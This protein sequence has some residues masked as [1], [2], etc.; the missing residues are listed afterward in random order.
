MAD[1]VRKTPEL[2]EKEPKKVVLKDVTQHH[3]KAAVTVVLGGG[4]AWLV[5]ALAT[6]F[7]IWLFN[8]QT[9]YAILNERVAA[10]INLSV[11]EIGFIAAVYTWVF[12]I[13]QLFSG[14]LLDKLGSRKILVPSIAMVS[15]GVFVYAN[16]TSFSG[17]LVSQI[18]IAIGSCA[19]FVGAGYVGG[20]WFGMAKFGFMFGLVQML[21]ALSS[22]FGQNLISFALESTDWR[23]L[24][25]GFGAFGVALL[26]VSALF[27]K[28]PT[29]VDT[30]N[31]KISSLPSD[32]VKSV[33]SVVKNRQI[34]LIALVGA[35]A[36]G[37]L[38]A[39]GVVWLPKLLTAHG[40][41]YS[42]TIMASSCLWLGLAFGSAFIN[43]ISEKF[44][45]RKHVI[46]VT[47]FLEIITLGTLIY[48]PVSPLFS[49]VLAFVFGTANAGH[50][51][52]FTM[53]AESVTPD[54]IGT[55]ASVV[56]GTMFVVG[57]VLMSAP[58]SVLGNSALTLAHMQTAISVILG[59]LIVAFVIAFAQKETFKTQ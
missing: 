31:V 22:A 34:I 3:K 6:T 20:I 49:Y 9:G 12:A 43:Q 8:I 48:A 17:I 58:G 37:A 56:N 50:M 42:S 28:N 40:F 55:S 7:V 41:E 23:G 33:I 1:P 45:S 27:L 57:G 16:A 19:G 53:A 44:R 24:M 2:V 18:I 38:L 51:L 5:W 32:V 13:A 46:T 4:R 26:A 25:N 29:P 39:L 35:A 15:L 47:L 30:S 21:A 14:A 52:A 54:K 10:A 59:T 11:N 36:F